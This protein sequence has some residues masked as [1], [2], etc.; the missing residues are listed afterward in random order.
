[1]LD[2]RLPVL[3]REFHYGWDLVTGAIRSFEVD[4]RKIQST[5]GFFM[6]SLRSESTRSGVSTADPGAPFM[7]DALEALAAMK[8]DD[9]AAFEVLRSQL[10]T[11]GCRVTALDEAIA[12]E[13]GR[14]HRICSLFVCVP[15]RVR[16]Q[17]PQAS[18]E[19]ARRIRGKN[20]ASPMAIVGL[21]RY[22]QAPQWS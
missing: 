3:E 11:A 21:K 22:L 2:V 12:E 6:E 7:P 20:H 5:L 13:N 14:N 15:S 17:T 9:R 16:A 19:V 8:K 4:L 1:T 18:R 10:N